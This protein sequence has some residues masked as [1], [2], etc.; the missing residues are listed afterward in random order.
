MRVRCDRDLFDLCRDALRQRRP[1]G[2]TVSA[3]T[4]IV[5]DAVALHHGMI[6][7]N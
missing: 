2:P 3:T 7:V 5:K 4:N 6:K 1:R